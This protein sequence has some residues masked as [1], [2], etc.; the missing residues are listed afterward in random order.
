M[1][2]R[3]SLCAQVQAETGSEFVHPYNDPQVIAGQGTIA[4]ELLEQVEELDA[5][6]VPVSGGGMI[7]GIATWIKSHRPSVLV[8]AA[9]PTGNNNAADCQLAKSSGSLPSPPLPKPITIADGLQG[10]LGTNT[11]PIVKDLVDGVIVVS[12]EEIV[13][14]MRLIYLNA[15]TVVEPSGAVGVAA[16]VKERVNKE[17]GLLSQCK[18]V[19]VILCGGNVDLDS[20][21]LFEMKNWQPA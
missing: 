14:A 12:D 3:E 17:G 18:N 1:D 20:K 11:W 15:K 21:G 19:A 13:A 2:S 9:E 16:V 6:V 5:V 4:L 7:S 10:R 8:I